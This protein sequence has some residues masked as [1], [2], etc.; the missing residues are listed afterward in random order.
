MKFSVVIPT[1]NRANE[2]N[3][4]L[5]SLHRQTF[6]DFEVIIC[7]D[8]STDHTKEIVKAFSEKLLIKYSYEPNWGG[9]ARP[10]NIG[11]NKATAEWICFLDS[12][13]TWHESKLEVLNDYMLKH[14]A[15]IYYHLFDCE[16]KTMGNHS[17]SIF[18]SYLESFL[19]NGNR[20]VNSSI[21]IKK[22]VFFTVGGFSEDKRLIAIED[23]DL[24]IR[25][26]KM[27]FKF[28][29][30]SKVLGAYSIN[31]TN[32]SANFFSSRK[33][34]K[35]L[36]KI[37]NLTP[38]STLK[39]KALLDYMSGSFLLNNGRPR[40]ARKFFNSGIQYGSLGIK[41]KSMIKKLLSFRN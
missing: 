39:S 12:D 24:L 41:A 27:G 36:F 13:D 32:I 23:Y 2:L 14:K 18:G 15:D 29:K 8:G 16:G 19:R 35:Y 26:A 7:D 10:R 40:K 4:V 22:S 5:D 3:N 37:H 34:L 25:V 30:I 6:K 28:V 20:V 9:P 11:A 21:C 31:D 33:K 17:K 1:Y 38:K